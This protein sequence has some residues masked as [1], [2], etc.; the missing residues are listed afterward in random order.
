MVNGSNIFSER[1]EP[2]FGWYFPME[3]WDNWK[4]VQCGFL[5]QA[6]FARQAAGSDR[7]DSTPSRSP[8]ACTLS[9]TRESSNWKNV[10]CEELRNLWRLCLAEVYD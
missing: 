9:Q 1:G 3:L 8:P 10:Q 5:I 6:F 7:V 4:N 2:G